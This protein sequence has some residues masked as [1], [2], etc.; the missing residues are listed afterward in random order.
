MLP[1][2]LMSIC[3]ARFSAKRLKC[4]KTWITQFYLQIISC[5]PLLPAAKHH[6]H[7]AGTHFTVPRRVERWVDLSGWLHTEIKYSASFH[8]YSVM[9]CQNEVT[10]VMCPF[11]RLSVY[12]KYASIV[13]YNTIDKHKSRK[14]R[15]IAQVLG[16]RV[17]CQRPCRNLNG[18]P[19]RRR[20]LEVGIFSSAI[21]DQ[22]RAISQN[23]CKTWTR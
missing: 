18:L 9:L 15:T 5:L 22:Y 20:Q 14:R 19:Q 17:L 8:F 6:R 16:T 3:I 1:H 21:F 23:A 2:R 12:L 11:I 13:P 10:A 7:L 4:A